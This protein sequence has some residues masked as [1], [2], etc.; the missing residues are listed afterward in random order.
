M[1]HITGFYRIV[2]LFLLVAAT[3]I[4]SLAQ[5]TSNESDNAATFETQNLAD[6]VG[7]YGD[8]TVG[9]SGSNLTFQRE[10]MPMAVSLEQVDTDTFEIVI[11]PGA[12]VQGHAEGDM[13][14]LVF[15][16][17]EAGKVNMLRF[18]M[19]DGTEVASSSK[20]AP[21]ADAN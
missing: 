2:S 15:A 17:N 12:V 11:P 4:S 5:S 19:K 18:V 3:G 16:R 8:R 13:P 10:G 6:F 9:L 21:T 20:N 1:N 14:Q 7:M